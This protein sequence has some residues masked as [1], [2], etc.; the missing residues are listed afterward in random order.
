LLK[1]IDNLH[2]YFERIDLGQALGQN[3]PATVRR[4][5]R[6]INIPS[7]ELRKIAGDETEM[8]RQISMAASIQSLTATALN[9]PD[10]SG[11]RK[12][13]AERRAELRKRV[14]Q[15]QRA[16]PKPRVRSIRVSV[17]GFSR[18]AAEARVFTSW[19]KDACD[20]GNGDLRLCGIPVQVD[21]LGIFD[22]VASV[23]LANSSRLWKG[24]GG[25][26]DEHDLR[27]APYVRRCVHLVAA[28]E[29]RG[30]FPLDTAA[31][32]SGEEVVYPGVHSDVGGG[33]EPG[34]QGKAFIGD[35]IDD[36]AKLSQ[37][38]LCHMYREALAA[39]VPLNLSASRLAQRSKDAFKVD[40]G[41]IDAFNGYVAAT[42]GIKAG[43]SIAL[44]QAH[45]ALY[46][47]W[48]RLRL[49]DSTPEGMA[50]QPFVK[51]AAKYKQQD[52]TDLLKANAELRQEWAALQQD[53]QDSAY[54]T[55]SSV[56]RVLRR[57][58][59]LSVRDDFVA[60]LWGEKMKQWKEVKPAWNDLS[61]MDPRIVRLHDDY[62]H[63]SR[64]WFKPFGAANEEAWKRQYRERMA[65]LDAQDKAWQAWN[66]EV[67]P[68]IGDAVRKAQQ[69]PGSFQP[70][71]EVR[72]MPPLVAGKDLEDLKA[73]RS[74]GG[75]V[76]DEAEGRE[77][78]GMF[79][80]LRWRTIFLPAPSAEAS[81]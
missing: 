64:A 45:Y 74:S 55:Q 52:V 76:P 66:R 16:Q 62:S 28:H 61:P 71:P 63:D 70:T 17:F 39:G 59:I 25:Y 65:K 5:A 50:Q 46:L 2:Y 27:I 53:E 43:N 30:S 12:V 49:D 36:S 67:Q 23:G 22:T 13:L 75:V 54:S 29:V 51:R 57:M 24:H 10:H 42:A 6:D 8:L 15:W 80:F 44:I 7:M 77:S 4:M 47:R 18:G 1:F 40:K 38:A 31:G 48:R 56:G 37:I 60:A 26:A 34:E 68:V 21:L 58:T 73:W 32:V 78:Y 14:E 20:G 9:P 11:R 41:L 33:Y 19:L 69:N 72:P 79:G 35:S 3:D 81:A